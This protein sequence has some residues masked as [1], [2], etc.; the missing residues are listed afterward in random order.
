MSNN[1]TNK[2]QIMKNERTRNDKHYINPNECD[3]PN[4][5]H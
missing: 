1:S 5:R 3:Q 4:I 2:Q